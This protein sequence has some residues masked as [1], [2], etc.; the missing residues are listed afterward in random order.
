MK[1]RTLTLLAVW[2]LLGLFAALNWQALSAPTAL[3]LGLMQIQAPLGLIL[4]GATVLISGLFLFYIVF[5]QAH[6]LVETRRFTKELQSQ[7]ELADQ[8][9]A[10]RFTALQ[11]RLEALVQQQ[12]TARQ[13][14]EQ[15]L[16]ARTEEAVRELSAHLAE[17][18]DK[19]DRSLQGPAS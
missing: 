10:S 11:S 13:A 7:R 19:L 1:I 8:A 12:E 3:S 2:L 18:E 15:R 4:L 14:G 5:Q 9:E 16:L 6:L 17:M